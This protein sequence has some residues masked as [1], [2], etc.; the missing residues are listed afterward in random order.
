[1]IN[2]TNNLL[3]RKAFINYLNTNQTGEFLLTPTFG[4]II[5]MMKLFIKKLLNFFQM[6]IVNTII[7]K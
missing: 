1:M 4:H 5:A 3:T 2:I 6:K 7:Q